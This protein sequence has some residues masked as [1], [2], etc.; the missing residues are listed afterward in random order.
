M[1]LEKEITYLNSTNEIEVNIYKN[2]AELIGLGQSL[3]ALPFGKSL[4]GKQPYQSNLYDGCKKTIFQIKLKLL[5]V[6]V[7]YIVKNQ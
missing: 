3:F 1:N 4:L 6:Y 2:T 5:F 7:L